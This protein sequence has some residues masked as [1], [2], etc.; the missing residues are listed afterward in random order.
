[1]E[2]F[3]NINIFETK[4]IEYIIIIIFLLML[5]PFWVIFSRKPRLIHQMKE[6]LG[7]LTANLLRIPQGL[8]FSRNHT[9]AYLED[10]GVA[11]FGFDDFILKLAGN[12]RIYLLKTEGDII[13]KGEPMAVI[14]SNGKNL[15]FYAP[16]SGEII[17]GNRP[18]ENNPD[19]AKDDPYKSGWVYAVK[20]YD[21][22]SDTSGFALGEE[23]TN[24]MKSELD[25]FKD[26]LAVVFGKYSPEPSLA[27]FQEGGELKQNP[28]EELSI[29]IW[30][31]FQN[32]FLESI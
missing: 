28:M 9:W 20:P 3:T 29:E 26:F 32:E 15:R 31:N 6:S 19:L 12:I 23:A 1:M 7:G 5:I 22:K 13:L 16:V 8:F 2:G 10:S 21:W 11:K 14:E 30:N 27:V 18:L 17:A 24:W 4:G 25:R